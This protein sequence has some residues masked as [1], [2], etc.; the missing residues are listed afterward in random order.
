MAR[1][2]VVIRRSAEPE[3]AERWFYQLVLRD[4]AVASIG[5]LVGPGCGSGQR[6]FAL[7]KNEFPDLG[8]LRLLESS[9]GN[10]RVN[11]LLVSRQHGNA[12]IW[13]KQFEDR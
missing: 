7:E 13:A 1:Q 3:Q 8:G 6:A 5:I 11:G 10:Q 4:N 9:T 12:T 2:D